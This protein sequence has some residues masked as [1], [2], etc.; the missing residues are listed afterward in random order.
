MCF[1]DGRP[2]RDGYR[3]YKI[4]T[5]ANDDYQAMREV[6]SRRYREA[7]QGHELY[8][9]V[10]LIDGGRGQLNAAL[11]SFAGL[12]LQP[13]KVVALAKQEEV[14]F[15]D[16]KVKHLHDVSR[17]GVRCGLAAWGYN[18]HREVEEARRF[19][20]RV[21]RLNDVERQVFGTRC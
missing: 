13:P 6:V 12:K 17:L 16:D 20:H 21:F 2:W 15:I 7:G 8:P 4:R 10:I 11:E 5:A 9:D 1:I 14:L 3:R 18:G 19:G